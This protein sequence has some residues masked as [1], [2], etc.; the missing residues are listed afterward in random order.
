MRDGK[1]REDRLGAEQKIDRREQDKIIIVY[2]MY[3]NSNIICI[4]II[5]NIIYNI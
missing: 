2:N 4:C 3:N 1:R 5:Y